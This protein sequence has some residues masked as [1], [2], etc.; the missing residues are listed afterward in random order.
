LGQGLAL[1]ARGGSN[2]IA[3]FPRG[4]ES[5]MTRQ[6]FVIEPSDYPRSLNM[7]GERITVLASGAATGGYEI[8]LQE[9]PEGSGPPPHSH[10][11]DESFYVTRGEVLFG[12]AG[13]EKVAGP[14]TLVHL[15]GGT[16]HWFRF[17]K[18]GGQMISMTSREAASAMFE[19][20]ARDISPSAP[21][22]ARLVA[23]AGEHG[24]Q[25]SV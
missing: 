20:I 22:F 25:I 5:N 19:H 24:T 14:G 7:V 6:P 3:R 13:E 15:P 21:D 11:W 1:A 9:G 18:E 2:A 10:P 17:G 23:I 8:F 4:K 12:V 16:V